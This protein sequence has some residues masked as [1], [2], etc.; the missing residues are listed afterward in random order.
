MIRSFFSERRVPVVANK[1]QIGV[2][3]PIWSLS[4]DISKKVAYNLFE[5]HPPKKPHAEKVKLMRLIISESR[6][7]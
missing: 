7:K 5:K 3:L 6:L 4:V 1:F 2:A